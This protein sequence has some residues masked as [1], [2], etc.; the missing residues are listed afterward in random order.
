MEAVL[1]VHRFVV[2]SGTHRHTKVKCFFVA[3]QGSDAIS[4]G[5]DEEAGLHGCPA[6]LHLSPQSCPP[7]GKPEVRGDNEMTTAPVCLEV[8]IHIKDSASFKRLYV[9]S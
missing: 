7:A 8:E 6:E 3:R 9:F 2:F 5:S 4:C 1:K